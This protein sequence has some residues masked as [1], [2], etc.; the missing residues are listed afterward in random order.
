MS[1]ILHAIASNVGWILVGIALSGPLLW[2]QQRMIHEYRYQAHYDDITGLPNRWLFLTRLHA[3]LAADTPVGVVLL[4]L[5]RFKA[6]ND[7]FGHECGNDLLH[8][9]GRRLA[10]LPTPVAVAA[11]LSG[12]EFAL[13][14]RGTDEDTKAAAHAA[15]QIISAT[16]MQ[17]V[18]S[19]ITVLAS[20]GFTHTGRRGASAR[21]LLQEADDA[22]Y[23]AKKEGGV[24][25]YDP[26]APPRGRS[27]D[28]HAR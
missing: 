5:D 11:R 10:T 19:K 20:V 28:R 6:V 16:P 8:Q 2:R 9:I 13:L 26:F 14:V 25:R 22:M 4:D 18:N 17:L 7:T 15:W 3:M 27:R 21:Q 12:D 23:T 24:S 1:S